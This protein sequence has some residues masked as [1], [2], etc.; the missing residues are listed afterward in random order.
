[1]CYHGN[2]CLHREAASLLTAA[3]ITM[4]TCQSDNWKTLESPDLRGPGRDKNTTFAIAVC[5]VINQ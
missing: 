1:M 3:E 4:V 5:P 2:W